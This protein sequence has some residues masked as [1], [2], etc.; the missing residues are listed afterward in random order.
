M[1]EEFAPQKLH[2]EL[3]APKYSRKSANQSHCKGYTMGVAQ[4]ECLTFHCHEAA[5]KRES[6]LYSTRGAT[7]H[8]F[9]FGRPSAKVR[10]ESLEESAGLL[11][12]GFEKG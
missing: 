6:R 1:R 9:K 3:I 8:V 2:C 7:H 5:V 4:R 10:S 11:R 12:F